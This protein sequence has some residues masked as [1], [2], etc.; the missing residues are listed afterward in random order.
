[1]RDDEPLFAY[2]HGNGD[3]L[4]FRIGP[5]KVLVFG[6]PVLSHTRHVF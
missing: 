6:R 4:D 3:G 5:T 2:R 1:V